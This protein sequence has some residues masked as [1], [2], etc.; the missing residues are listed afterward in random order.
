MLKSVGEGMGVVGGQE[1]APDFKD[2]HFLYLI[3]K[4]QSNEATASSPH[5]KKG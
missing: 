4:G 1:A 5:N 3:T 2:T